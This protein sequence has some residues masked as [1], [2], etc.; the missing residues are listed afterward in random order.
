MERKTKTV[1]RNLRMEENKESQN[2]MILAH[3]RSG[4]SITSLEALYLYG[5]FRLSGRI[6][7]LRSQG[8]EIKSEFVKIRKGKLVKKYW[9][10]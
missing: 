2:K 6:Y 3:M 4:K 9:I 1:K 10:D 7:D 5:C 8:I